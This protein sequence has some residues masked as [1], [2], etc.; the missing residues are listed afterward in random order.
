[1]FGRVDHS[2]PGHQFVIVTILL[3]YFRMLVSSW[4]LFYRCKRLIGEDRALTSLT[5]WQYFAVRC[6]YGHWFYNFGLVWL[7]RLGAV[8]AGDMTCK[9]LENSS[10]S[11]KKGLL[12]HSMISAFRK[13]ILNHLITSAEN[14]FFVQIIH[15]KTKGICRVKALMLLKHGYSILQYL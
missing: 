13:K 7:T 3:T 2:T 10:W 4:R 15:T 14:I 9:N 8:V 11:H 12:F 5:D 6:R 1:M